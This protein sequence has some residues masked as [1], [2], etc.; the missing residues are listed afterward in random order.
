MPGAHDASE[1]PCSWCR[2]ALQ[3]R[4]PVR[5]A[6]DRRTRS[7]AALVVGWRGAVA[8]QA[9]TVTAPSAAILYLVALVATLLYL[10][11]PAD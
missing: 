5:A 11:V 7:G 4:L 8:I 6:V 2:L 10:A 9:G 3:S 1:S